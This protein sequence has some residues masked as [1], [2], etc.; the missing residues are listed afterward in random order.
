[1]SKITLLTPYFSPHLGGVESHVFETAKILS[2]DH[3]VQIV[4]S[5]H[6][7]SLKLEDKVNGLKVFRLPIGSK[8]QVWTWIWQ[9][10]DLF[11]SSDIV[12]VHDI[13]WWILPVWPLVRQKVYLTHHGW[14]GK[15]PV[16]LINKL[17]RYIYAK[18]SRGL[19]HVGDYIREFYWEKPAAVVYGGIIKSQMTNSLKGA[20]RA[21]KISINKSKKMKIVYIGRLEVENEIESYLKLI[22]ELRIKSEGLKIEVD[23]V[24]DGKYRKQCEKLG[25]VTGMITNPEK[26]L[27]NADVVFANSYLSILEAQAADKLVVSV[28]S[29]KLKQ[30]Y[31]E[32]WPGAEF[33]IIQDEG[34]RIEEVVGLLADEKKMTKI[35]KQVNKF[36]NKMTWEKVVYQYL[37]LW[38]N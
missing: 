27:Q 18:L 31:L 16:P 30:R 28:Y 15:Y 37:K 4:T 14:E 12:H 22:N 2:I 32:T 17:Q 36:A 33:M 9:H 13:F 20:P 25:H 19:V 24:G 38:K 34:L 3:E 29:N 26:Y 1:M 7:Q 6:D 5:Q 23:W 11:T 35:A 10:K 21:K 8:L